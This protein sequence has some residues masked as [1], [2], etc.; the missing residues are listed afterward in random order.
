MVQK[1]GELKCSLSPVAGA[2]FSVCDGQDLDL[3]WRFPIGHGVREVMKQSMSSVS[4]SEG[5]EARISPNAVG[6]VS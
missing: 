3:V 1:Q 6:G 5:I 2:T 4:Q